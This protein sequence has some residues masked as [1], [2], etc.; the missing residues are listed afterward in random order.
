MFLAFALGA[1]ALSDGT[2]CIESMAV[3]LTSDA[4]KAWFANSTI[5]Y[6]VLGV[7]K[8][9]LKEDQRTDA[10]V[11]KFKQMMVDSATASKAENGSLYYTWSHDI[12]DEYSFWCTEQWATHNDFVYHTSP[13]GAFGKVWGA[14]AAMCDSQVALVNYNEMFKKENA[15]HPA[16]A[17]HQV[18]S[19]RRRPP[20]LE[21]EGSSSTCP[22]TMNIAWDNANLETFLTD[23]KNLDS[24]PTD[25]LTKWTLK[26]PTTANMQ[27]WKGIMRKAEV[28]SRAEPGCD[29]YKF[30]KDLTDK[31]SFWLWEKWATKKEQIAHAT[32]GAFGQQKEEWFAM[33]NGLLA[34]YNGEMIT[35]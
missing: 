26:D 21:G 22:A 20:V 1:A 11:A 24:G 33:T 19:E 5:D 3:D 17:M 28:L 25:I 35:A 32:T 16:F 6:K 18:H 10:D 27:K 15:A 8:W 12:W 9:T 14:F 7:S 23:N 31:N 4:M 34:M 30:G 13:E 2:T 29:E